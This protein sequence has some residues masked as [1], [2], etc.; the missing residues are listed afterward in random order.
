ML[1]LSLAGGGAHRE[2]S[3]ILQDISFETAVARATGTP[4]SIFELLW[5]VEASQ[6]FLLE[7]AT[8]GEVD[9]ANVALWPSEES[10]AEFRRVLR[11]FQVGQAQAQMLAE[12]PSDRARDALTDLAVHNAYHLG[13]IVLLRRLHGDWTAS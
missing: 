7:H 13:Q 1:Q 12:A 9:W 11:D 3:K 10:E 5:H 8:G 6:R 2:V 4:H